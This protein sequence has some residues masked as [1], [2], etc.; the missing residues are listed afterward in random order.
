[1]HDDSESHGD[2]NSVRFGS[3]RGRRARV[4]YGPIREVR[5]TCSTPRPEPFV[6]G[7]QMIVFALR[8]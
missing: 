3:R 6:N 7:T 8:R 1:M 5:F 4:S 2:V